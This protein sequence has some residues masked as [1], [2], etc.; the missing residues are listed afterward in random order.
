MYGVVL[1]S[2]QVERKAVIWCEDHGD[3]AYYNAAEHSVFD[4]A[5]LD[6]GDLV[7]FQLEEG[8]SIRRAQNPELVA[9]GHAPALANRLRGAVSRPSEPAQRRSANVLAFP[10][11]EVAMA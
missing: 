3:L 5:S 1:W 4:G 9:Q 7:H 6:A 11:R 2:D 10:A 8:R